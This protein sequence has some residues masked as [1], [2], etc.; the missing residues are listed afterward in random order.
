ML[1]E[2]LSD[3]GNRMNDY[4]RLHALLEEFKRRMAGLGGA[5]SVHWA[6]RL[7]AHEN[8][9]YAMSLE[10]A[11]AADALRE[12]IVADMEEL[13]E[14]PRRAETLGRASRS[15]EAESPAEAPRLTSPA[16]A[17]RTLPKTPPGADARFRIRL[18]TWA[19][20][21]IAVL[22]LAG[23]GYGELYMSKATFGAD[24]WGD[25]FSLIAWG[26]GAEASRASVAEMV[27]GWGLGL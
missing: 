9:L 27:K 21:G 8:A 25:Y 12:T 3:L 7:A 4:F 20:Y 24:P 2:R 11:D 1:R 26:F 22:L 18:F 13:K 15:G 16:P 6:G 5:E 19:T 23:A 10:D 17:A 14:T